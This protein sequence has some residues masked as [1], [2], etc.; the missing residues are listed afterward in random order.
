M[1][2]VLAHPRRSPAGTSKSRYR[3]PAVCWHAGRLGPGRHDASGGCCPAQLSSIMGYETD[4]SRYRGVG[5]RVPSSILDDHVPV[6]IHDSF[7]STRYDLLCNDSFALTRVLP[8]L[9]RLSSTLTPPDFW[10]ILTYYTRSPRA[11]DV[12]RLNWMIVQDLDRRP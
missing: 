11:S 10:G 2:A 5:H 12:R 3:V 8:C 4:E 1:G 9:V 7:P 6:T